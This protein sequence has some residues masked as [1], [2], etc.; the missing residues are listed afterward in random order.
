[1]LLRTRIT[2]IVASGFI[3][4]MVTFWASSLV[5]DRL[6]A[7]RTAAVAISGQAALWREIM[8]V[9]V[10]DLLQKLDDMQADV[11]LRIAVTFANRQGVA[12]AVVEGFVYKEGA[13]DLLPGETLMLFTDGVTEAIDIDGELYGDPRLEAFLATGV[14]DWTVE[15]ICHQTLM[16]IREFER[17]APQADDI[18]CLALRYFGG[19]APTI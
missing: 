19:R 1:M 9:Q 12:V 3:A 17:G 18:T 13:L 8:E 10:S 14:W 4:L 6:E 2:L 7:D 11:N 5:R 16:S 15:E